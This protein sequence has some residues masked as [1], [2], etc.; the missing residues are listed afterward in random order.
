VV[1]NLASGEIY[2]SFTVLAF[3]DRKD[4]AIVKV[5]GFELP[6]IELGN[7]SDLKP[8]ASVMAIGSPSGLQGTVTAGVVSAI[9]DD[10]FSGGYKVIQTDAASNPGN[11]AGPL[12][13]EKGQAIGIITSKVKDSEGLNFAV[14]INYVRGLMASDMKPMMLSEMR[15]A[16]S[17]AAPV[18]SFKDAGS[19]PTHWK[20]VTSGRTF[21]IRKEAE[22]VY[23]ERVLS[24]AEKQ[25][26][27]YA[28]MELHKSKDGYSG[29]EHVVLIGQYFQRGLNARRVANRCAIDYPSS[30]KLLTESR[31]EGQITAPP[32]DPNFDFK[33]CVS[34]KKPSE[35][36]F[37]WIP[38]QQ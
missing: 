32:S 26:G 9:R 37:V 13:D 31:I 17:A 22:I 6:A 11:S 19:F 27:V 1:F 34:P 20:S 30:I 7:S 15:T 3:D 10:P 5:P 21:V 18:G 29:V 38:D 28:G 12:I 36:A 8:G 35:Q 14:P 24:D 4:I 33:K 25:A 23:V 16:L 2:D